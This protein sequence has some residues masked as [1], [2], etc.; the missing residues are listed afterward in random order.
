MI[1][2]IIKMPISITIMLTWIIVWALV[3]TN[4]NVLPAMCGKGI[5]VVGNEYYRFFTAGLTH[6]HVLHMLF[7]VI[8]MFWIG[9]LYEN[10]IGS[11]T[12]L[13]IAVICAVATQVI[14]LCI[15]SG[16]TESIGGSGYNFAFI[17]F[18]LTMQFL[19]PSFPKITFG[20]WSGN[21]LIISAILGN[22]PIFS[23]MNITTFIFHLIAFALGVCAAFVCWL[24]GMK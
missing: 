23:F 20:T 3:V 14:F 24:L 18:G 19:S 16:A 22:F 12:F 2:E 6:F 21:W 4:K 11:I 15:Y 17:G 5:S 9:Y 1:K 13:L 8:A 7:N 10:Y